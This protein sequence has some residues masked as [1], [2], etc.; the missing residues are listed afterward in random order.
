MKIAVTGGKGGTGKSTVATN[1]SVVLGRKYSVALGDL[2]VECPNDHILLSAELNNERKVE[3]FKPIFDYAKC[4]KC[5]VCKNICQENA[6][7]MFRNNYPFLIPNLCSG[8]T[9]C[10]LACSYNAIKDGSKLVG[11]TYESEIHGI[12][13]FTG[14]LLEGEE[15][16][17]PV[18]LATLKRIFSYSADIYIVDTSAGTSNSVAKSLESAD[19]VV[20]VTEPTPLGA[21][22][23]E[24][25]LKLTKKLNLKTKIVVNRADIGNEKI[26]KIA[27]K[28]SS[29][30]VMEIPYSEEIVKSYMAGRP[31]VL[32]GGKMAKY[33]E[34]L[35]KIIEEELYGDSGG[36]R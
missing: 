22:D 13:L 9:A 30:I 14:M 16:A 12:K 11:H 28:Y 34:D 8:C 10:K 18:V 15:R 26:D 6:I 24:G 1:I 7:V 36:E 5:S 27:E 25:I 20:A 2:D 3:I 17:Y 21:H 35:A 33:Y 32:D 19:L 4:T 23:L 29:E 31:V